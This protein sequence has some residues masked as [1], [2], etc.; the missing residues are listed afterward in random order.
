MTKKEYPFGD[1][2]DII[3]NNLLYSLFLASHTPFRSITA[4]KSPHFKPGS[5][6]TAP[7]SIVMIV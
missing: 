1:N 2:M 7:I 4:I 6:L 5:K 3:E